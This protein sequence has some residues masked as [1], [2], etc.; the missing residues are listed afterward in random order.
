MVFSKQEILPGS[1]WALFSMVAIELHKNLLLIY[2][3]TF[4]KIPTVPTRLLGIA[5]YCFSHQSLYL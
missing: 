4:E 3:K 5:K 1:A 2:I